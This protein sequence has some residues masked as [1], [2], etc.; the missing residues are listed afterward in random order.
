MT[1]NEIELLNLIRENDKPE[2]A[3]ITAIGIITSFL[4]QSLSYQESSV[5]FLQELA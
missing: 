5:D 1:K 2:E 4:E 3:L